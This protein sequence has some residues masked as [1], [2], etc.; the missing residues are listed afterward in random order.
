MADHRVN[1][2]FASSTYQALEDLAGV[3]GK[4][5]SEVLRDAIVHE[6]WFQDARKHG[7][8]VLVEEPNGKVREIIS[9]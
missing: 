7:S 9:L 5:K 3:K 2:N 8:R 6:K 4:S 1:V